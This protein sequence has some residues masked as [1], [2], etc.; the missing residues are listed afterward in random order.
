MAEPTVTLLAEKERV[1][2]GTRNEERT[3]IVRS[4][5]SVFRDKIAAKKRESL[6]A[7]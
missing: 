5:G 1:R 6:V 7:S 2:Q 3:E 4:R